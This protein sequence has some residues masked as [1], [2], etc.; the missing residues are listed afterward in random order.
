MVVSTVFGRNGFSLPGH[1]FPNFGYNGFML[2]NLYSRF[3]PIAYHYDGNGFTLSRNPIP[4]HDI[5]IELDQEY[6][7]HRFRIINGM[8][9]ITDNDGYTMVSHMTDVFFC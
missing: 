9:G 3:P 6:C 1:I 4:F 5:A 7:S 8:V 2:I